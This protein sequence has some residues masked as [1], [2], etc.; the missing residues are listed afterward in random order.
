MNPVINTHGHKHA[1][2]TLLELLIA[3]ILSIGLTMIA[4]NFW[5][6]SSRQMSG[7]NSRVCVAQELRLAVDSIA[8]DMGATVGAAPVGENRV[9]LCRDGGQEPNGVPEWGPPDS[10]V[11]YSMVDGQLFRHEQSS[12][13]EIVVADNIS[14]FTVEQITGSLLRMMIEVEDGEI[15]RQVILIWSKP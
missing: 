14:A 12:G 9:L 2:F 13:L 6:Y 7:L 4:A 1:G 11:T 10:M 5:R 15:T 3:A 8:G